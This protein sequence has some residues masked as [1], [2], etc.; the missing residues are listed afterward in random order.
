[1]AF[2]QLAPL[3]IPHCIIRI[4]LLGS[5]P[6]QIAMLLFLLWVSEWVSEWVKVTQSCLTLCDSMDNT[7]HGIL[8]ASILEWVAFPFSRG[9]SQP[10]NW[11]GVSCIA[12]RFFTNWATRKAHFSYTNNELSQPPPI[13]V[14]FLYSPSEQNFS[15]KM[16]VFPVSIASLPILFFFKPAPIRF[17]PPSIPLKLQLLQLSVW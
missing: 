6:Q 13:F 15:K 5:T 3:F 14:L 12:G 11:T 8:Q 1:M 16:S 9:S 7:V 4:S 10:R 17:C 2:Q